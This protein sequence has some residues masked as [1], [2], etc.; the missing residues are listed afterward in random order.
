MLVRLDEGDPAGPTYGAVA[1]SS[2]SSVELTCPVTVP[3]WR[4]TPRSA[5][6]RLPS[7]ILMSPPVVSQSEPGEGATPRRAARAAEHR[8]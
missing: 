6:S 7:A 4:T 8:V 1:L 5:S 2:C 3:A